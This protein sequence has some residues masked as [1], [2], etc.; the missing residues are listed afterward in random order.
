MAQKLVVIGAGMASGR[1]LEELFALD[2]DAYDVT[3]FGAEPRGSYNRLMLSPVLSGEKTCEEIITHD[4]AWYAAHRV[5]CRFGEAVTAIDRA[6]KVVITAQGETP[7][8]KLIVAT[9][10]QPLIIPVPGKD[11][12]G[13]IAFRDLDDVNRMREAAAVPGAKAVVIGGGLLGLEAAAGLRM[14]GMEVTVLHLMP[15]LMERQLDP[16]AA[17]LLQK[18]LE[19][20]GISVRCKASTHSIEGSGKVEGVRLDDGA[21]IP[22][23]IV[24]MAVGIRPDTALAKDAG[25]ACG[26]GVH[27]DD[28]MVTSDPDVLG[29]GECVE[30]DGMVYG[31]VGPLYEMGR[32]L[33]RTLVGE[34]GAY[35]GSVMNA[36]LK[37]TGVDLFSAGDFAEGDDRDEIVFRDPARGVYKRIVLRDDKVIGAVMYG[38]TADGAWFFGLLKDRTD[39]AEMRDM[40][41]FGPAFQ[42][43]TRLDPMAAVAALPDGAEICGCNGVCKGSIVNAIKTKG[44]SS[45]EDVRAHT[46][47]SSS[48]GTCSGLVEQVMAMTLGDGF[49]AKRNASL[50]ACTELTH[51]DVRRLIKSKELRTMPAVMQECGWKTSC[52]CA[53]CRPALNRYLL[54]AAAWG[55]RPAR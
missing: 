34:A 21:V 3:L 46:R 23:D 16:A 40:L 20:R 12:P 33:A 53:S 19:R 2:P 22:A 43:G 36:R 25:L 4:A 49:E 44:L 10:S 55:S 13:V 14:Q 37:V 42:G 41:V 50:C 28:R 24:V 27:V 51:M 11:L 39:V 30:H 54:R 17:Y 9:G 47:A 1:A 29:V 31:L 26:R 45:L 8:D 38:D 6:R 35:R 15:H 48:C 52:G 32:V 18:E 7:Y 5:T